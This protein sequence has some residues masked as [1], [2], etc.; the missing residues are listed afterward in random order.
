MEDALWKGHIRKYVANIKFNINYFFY[1]R[2][3]E[4]SEVL[5]FKK[6]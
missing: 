4:R 3:R 6:N 1:V 5:F 2:L